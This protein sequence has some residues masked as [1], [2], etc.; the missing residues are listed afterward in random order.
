MNEDGQ[1]ININGI[2]WTKQELIEILKIMANTK[3]YNVKY[4]SKLINYL[5]PIDMFKNVT[6]KLSIEEFQKLIKDSRLT[7]D[8]I[9]TLVGVASATVNRW[10]NGQYAPTIKLQ[11]HLVDVLNDAISKQKPKDKNSFI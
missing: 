11:Q 2:E 6:N 7:D 4:T 10:R 9:A 5:I 1:L 3:S 8:E